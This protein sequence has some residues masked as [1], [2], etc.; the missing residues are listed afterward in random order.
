ML[1]TLAGGPA[2]GRTVIGDTSIDAEG[3]VGYNLLHDT[4]AEG[5]EDLNSKASASIGAEDDV[6]YN[7]LY[8]TAAEEFEDLNIKALRPFPHYVRGDFVIPSVGQ[9]EMGGR[10]FV[11]FLD[12]FGKLQKFHIDG[13]Q[14]G[15]TYRMME[16]GF[17]NMSRAEKTIAPGLLFYET[18]PP[19]E[20][21]WYNPI[22]NMPPYAPNDNTYVNTIQ[23]GDA[24]M[25]L[26]DSAAMLQV[27]PRTMRVIGNNDWADD[28]QDVVCCTGSAHPLPDPKTGEWIGLLGNSGILS[29]ETTLRLFR[30]GGDSPH[31]RRSVA[32]VRMDTPPYIHSFGVSERF[33]I[34]P[35]MPVKFSAKSVAVAPLSAA[36]QP[37]EVSKEGLE[38]AF[39]IVPLDGSPGIVRTVPQEEPLWFTHVVNTYEN[40]SGVVIDIVQAPGNPFASDLTVDAARDK[41]KRDIAGVAGKNLVKRFLLPLDSDVPVSSALI[42]DAGTFTDFP[43]INPKYR[44]RQHCFYWAN[45]W[46][47][48]GR[49]HASM[50]V[51]KYDVC[52]GER[53][54]V[55]SRR[56]WYPSEATMVPSDREGAAED[57][58]VLVFVALDGVRGE[59][60]LLGV[61]ARTMETVSEAGPFPRIGFTTHGEFYPGGSAGA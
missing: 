36:F 35:R 52:S 40:A 25:A 13:D 1:L 29:E 31:T 55:W 27:D 5:F 41:R 10:K 2:S 42:S 26:T 39:Y 54:R 34:L 61:D 32:D 21:P 59:T 3:D 12:S 49:A 57:E 11:G 51:V 14:V 23:V 30:F 4:A 53:K 20:K 43:K 37:L 16:S 38:N 15:A 17:Y 48:D 44:S 7:L 60:W 9:F 33:A 50:A 8:E 45:E 6:G 28:L 19:R 46:F 22:Y 47:S 24:M 18:S 58:G 56:H